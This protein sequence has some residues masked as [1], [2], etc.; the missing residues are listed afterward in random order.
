MFGER[1]IT[2]RGN[3]RKIRTIRAQIYPME[4]KLSVV[5][6]D[7]GVE[8]DDWI[9]DKACQELLDQQGKV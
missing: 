2:I 6:F 8:T 4:V 5:E 7:E 9:A 1:K 3:D